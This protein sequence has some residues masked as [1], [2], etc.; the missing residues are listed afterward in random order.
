MNFGNGKHTC[1]QRCALTHILF[2]LHILWKKAERGAT[3]SRRREVSALAGVDR[4]LHGDYMRQNKTQDF[5]PYSRKRFTCL[6]T[7]EKESGL[8]FILKRYW[9][10]LPFDVTYLK[11]NRR[12]RGTEELQRALTM[13]FCKEIQQGLGISSHWHW[14]FLQFHALPHKVNFTLTMISLDI[15][16]QLDNEP[17][18]T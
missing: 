13:C 14:S 15:I 10:E 1:L 2:L 4:A 12:R 11:W 8:N 17:K 18:H 16:L 9:A 5:L 6:D 3:L 7:C